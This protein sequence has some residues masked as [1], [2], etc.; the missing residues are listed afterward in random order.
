VGFVSKRETGHLSVQSG[1]IVY[2]VNESD[3]EV[4]LSRDSNSQSA[5]GSTRDVT[6]HQEVSYKHSGLLSK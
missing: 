6:A 2:D 5:A 4:L 1:D 3:V